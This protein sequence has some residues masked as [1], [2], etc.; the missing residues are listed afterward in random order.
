MQQADAS[1]HP[2]TVEKEPTQ[3]GAAPEGYEWITRDQW[4]E[5]RTATRWMVVLG[6]LLFWGGVLGVPLLLGRLAFSRILGVS[7]GEPGVVGALL[8]PPV[9]PL[10]AVVFGG[11]VLWIRG[12]R[13]RDQLEEALFR[14]DDEYRRLVA[15][16]GFRWDCV[17]SLGLFG[18]LV[19]IVPCVLT[20]A[21]FAV[22]AAAGEVQT[23]EHVLLD[24]VAPALFLV[25]M[26]LL[27]WWG[28]RRQAVNGPLTVAELARLSPRPLTVSG[29]T[30]TEAV[31]GVDLI[32]PF[33]Q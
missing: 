2:G 30:A 13:E 29:I 32:P 31:S 27:V 3:A 24:A 23:V 10:L 1:V 19:G 21:W 12:R 14:E 4:D 18:L 7:L 15:V 33:D 25:L 20:L 8:S 5:R 17:V 16:G 9:G 11:M 6:A 26:V 28:R 22:E